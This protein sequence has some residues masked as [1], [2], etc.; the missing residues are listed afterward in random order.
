MAQ[1][2]K[3]VKLFIVRSLAVFNTPSETAEAVYQEFKVVVTKQNCEKYDPTKRAGQNLS[4]ELKAEFEATRKQFLE[5]PQHIPIANLAYRLQLMQ[6][7]INGAGKNSVLI[8][9]TLEQAAKDE[10]GAFT[11]RKEITGADGKPLEQ[12]IYQMTPEA[13]EAIAKALKDEY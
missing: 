11:N 12:N 9:K 13:A 1:I 10:G 4:A 8:L 2:K 7:V 3:E 6:R 5:N